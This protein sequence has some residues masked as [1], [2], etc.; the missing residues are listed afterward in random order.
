MKLKQYEQRRLKIIAQSVVGKSVLDIG[1]AQLPNKFLYNFDCI[2]Y[3]INKPK[4]NRDIYTEQILGDIKDIRRKL[5]SRK[6]D[7]IVCGELI[8][9]L[10]N[11]YQFLRDLQFLLKKDGHLILSTPNPLGFPIMFFELSRN[12][13]F[14]YTKDHYYYFLP[15]WV[16]RL[17]DVSGYNVLKIIPVGLWFGFFYIPTSPKSLSY[18]LIYV[19]EKKK[20]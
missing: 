2:G 20:S 9:H 17:L 18:Q 7:S 1:N 10:E 6:F 19:A 11:P 8:E 15:R 16:E 5:S 12:K 13:K 14:F 3:D 4:K